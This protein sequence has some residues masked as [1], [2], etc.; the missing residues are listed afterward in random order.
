MSNTYKPLIEVA[1]MSQEKKKVQGQVIVEHETAFGS[2][3]GTSSRQ[4]SN[5]SLNG[6]FTNTSL[7]TRRLSLGI[8]QLGNT[9]INSASQPVSY[10]KEAR[11]TQG[12]RRLPRPGFTSQFRDETASVVS[13]FSGPL[14]P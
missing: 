4:I 1:F 8:Q 6:G 12:Q 2:R 10:I 13:T 7:S 9:S 5:R 3:P 11:K 14:S